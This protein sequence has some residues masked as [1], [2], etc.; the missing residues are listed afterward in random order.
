MLRKSY[1]YIWRWVALISLIATILFSYFYEQLLPNAKTMR[2]VTMAY[3]TLF[4]PAPYTF[5]IWGLIYL[6]LTAYAVYQLLPS[7]KLLSVYDT[8]AKPFT[9]VNFMTSCWVFSFSEA[10]IPV[11]MF[12]I[13]LLLISSIL[14]FLRSKEGILRDQISVWI[15]V[16]FSLLLSWL[17]MATA[18]NLEI[19]LAYIG[20][21]G[22]ELGEAPIAILML[23]GAMSLGIWTSSTF[24][25]FVF[26]LVISWASFGISVGQKTANREVSIAGFII[27]IILLVW[28]AGLVIWFNGRKRHKL[29]L[30]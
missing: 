4:T 10:E 15:S 17:C 28:T 2:E 11:S 25:D 3:P 24:K 18:A 7:Q 6:A 14:L 5:S 23:A 8:L 30:Q 27:G 1:N 29:S 9:F 19:L 22:G 12:F 26:P 20:W 13:I 21:R 16:P